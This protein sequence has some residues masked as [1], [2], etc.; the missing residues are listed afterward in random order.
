MTRERTHDTRHTSLCALVL[1]DDIFFR[2]RSS[3]GRVRKPHLCYKYSRENTPLGQE[4]Q[5]S[6][7]VSIPIV[8]HSRNERM[9]K[10]VQRQETLSLELISSSSFGVGTRQQERKNVRCKLAL[11]GV[12]RS[13]AVNRQLWTFP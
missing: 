9:G 5:R 7:S 13:T 2:N 12:S 1:Q 3:I 4:Q 10:N 8:A 11:G 6:S